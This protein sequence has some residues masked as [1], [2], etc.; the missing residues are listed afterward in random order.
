MA[1]GSPSYEEKLRNPLA[2]SLALHVTIALLAVGFAWWR[3]RAVES[4][5]V[6][7]PGAGAYSVQV[8]KSINIAARP[9]R[10]NP[11]ADDAESE[12]E[13]AP[14]DKQKKKP[15]EKKLFDDEGI[16]LDDKPSQKKQN[17][18][19]SMANANPDPNRVTSTV[20]QAAVAPMFVQTGGGGI[21]IG[22]NE[23]IGKNYGWYKELIRRRVAEHWRQDEIS[24]SLKTSNPAIVTFEIQRNG[25]V[26]NV[27]LV[28][29]SGISALDYSAQRA[30][31]EAAP[32]PELPRQ[33]EKDSATI[34][35]WFELKR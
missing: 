7:N 13:R 1:H 32:F 6:E 25:A 12:I 31:Q 15:S 30:I 17:N 9:G 24:T 5:G 11:V 35:F 23:S 29:A 8:V 18:P 3:M 26:R 10:V 28:K 21:G 20:G 4:F 34:E 33:F 2:V 19:A 16:V 27:R 22:Q 14:E